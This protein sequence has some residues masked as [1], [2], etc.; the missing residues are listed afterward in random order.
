MKAIQEWE[1]A[2]VELLSGLPGT[3]V[4]SAEATYCFSKCAVTETI[5]WLCTEYT[6]DKAFRGCI[7]FNQLLVAA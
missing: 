3:H 7:K 6:K 5:S 2:V 1:L 4:I